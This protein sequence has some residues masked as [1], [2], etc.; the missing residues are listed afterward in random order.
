MT[1]LEEWLRSAT[2]SEAIYTPS[3][4]EGISG[5]SVDLQRVWRRRGQLPALAGKHARF[6]IADV[7]EITIRTALSRA[8][9]P[10]SDEIDLKDATKAAKYHAVFSH[11]AVELIGPAA[12]VDCLYDY[13]EKDSDELGRLLVGDPSQTS[14]L[15]L[16]AQR[17]TRIVDRLEDLIAHD[18][19]LN[20]VYNIQ[21]LG[22]LLVERGRKPVF[23]IQWPS[24][25]KVRQKRKLTGL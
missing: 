17:Q 22:V 10:P 3:E 1:S 5:L 19:E 15:V 24:D 11:A 9:V 16:T 7:V 8:G 18:E 25:P 13:F 6:T 20:F 2:I 23:I 14:Y 4:L 21:R 12:A